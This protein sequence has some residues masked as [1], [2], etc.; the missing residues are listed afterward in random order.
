MF[1]N[2]G[3]PEIITR[4]EVMWTYKL[5]YRARDQERPL[6]LMRQTLTGGMKETTFSETICDLCIHNY[7]DENG[8][9]PPYYPIKIQGHISNVHI[10]DETLLEFHGLITKDEYDLNV[11]TKRERESCKGVQCSGH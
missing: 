11:E 2:N 4:K 5:P 7:Y 10:L 1:L 8:A 6:L 9:C 3:Q